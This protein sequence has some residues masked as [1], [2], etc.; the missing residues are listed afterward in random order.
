MP[1]IDYILCFGISSDV[2]HKIEIISNNINDIKTFSEIILNIALGVGA[3]KGLIFLKSFQEK[4][5][6][7]TFTFWLQ[8]KVRMMEIKGWI[9]NDKKLVNYLFDEESRSTWESES[10]EVSPRLSAFK[11]IIVETIQFVKK[12]PDQIPAYCGWT[13]DY[14]EFIKFLEDTI[15]YDICNGGDYFKFYSPQTV[16]DRDAYCD[17]ICK[18]LGRMCDEIERKQKEIE[19]R[20]QIGI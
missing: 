12:T 19:K 18:I 6:A 7:A 3:V 8:L 10:S 13:D 1:A 17:N 9:E 20:L 14:T 5:A 15:Q 2:I 11:E 4:R 16:A